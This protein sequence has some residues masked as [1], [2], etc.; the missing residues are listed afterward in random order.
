MMF[1]AVLVEVLC[2]GI[3]Q[4]SRRMLLVELEG[5]A[6]SGDEQQIHARWD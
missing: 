3:V 5:Q 2:W 4:R 1:I 6:R